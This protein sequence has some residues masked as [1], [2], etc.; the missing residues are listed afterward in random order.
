MESKL[1]EGFWAH[2]SVLCEFGGVVQSAPLCFVKERLHYHCC[3]FI[4]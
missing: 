3:N 1:V 2:P 4:H